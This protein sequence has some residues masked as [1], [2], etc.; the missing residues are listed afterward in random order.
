ML[1]GPRESNAQTGA[2]RARQGS[3]LQIC[4]HGAQR[5]GL[6]KAGPKALGQGFGRHLLE[7]RPTEL[8]K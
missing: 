4:T 5:D 7:Q 6:E 8:G 2:V 1:A 3:R